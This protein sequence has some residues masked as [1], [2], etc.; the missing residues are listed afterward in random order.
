MG[1]FATLHKNW[2]DAKKK[3]P[4]QKLAKKIFSKGL[5]PVL[6]DLEQTINDLLDARRSKFNPEQI[7][8]LSPK[9]Q[10]LCQKVAKI[11][12]EYKKLAGTNDWA[13]AKSAA[14]KI[15]NEATAHEAEEAKEWMPDK[16]YMALWRYVTLEMALSATGLEDAK[17]AEDLRKLL[18][19]KNKGITSAKKDERELKET[20]EKLS[21]VWLKGANGE[22][23]LKRMADGIA[24]GVVLATALANPAPGSPQD[25]NAPDKLKKLV[26]SV[27]KTFDLIVLNLD[28]IDR[29][30]KELKSYVKKP[31]VQNS[32]WNK[33]G[34]DN[35]KTGEDYLK[36][37]TATVNKCRPEVA[38]LPKVT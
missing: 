25:P 11:A 24:Q 7:S 31:E 38:R 32:S 23:Y 13:E 6:D 3:V 17:T 19:K 29:D 26:P 20:I 33:L 36:W 1:T 27:Q 22:D 15:V 37:Y 18:E 28:R 14:I 9:V 16:E 8:K 5:G 12:T 10:A 4:D 21:R 30:L 2:A 35:V 34:D